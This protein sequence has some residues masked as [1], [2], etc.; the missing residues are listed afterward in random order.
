MLRYIY[1]ENHAIADLKIRFEALVDTFNIFDST[2]DST[3]LIYAGVRKD[4]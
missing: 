3:R 2:R 1:D 4:P